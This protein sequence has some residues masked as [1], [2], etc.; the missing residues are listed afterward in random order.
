MERASLAAAYFCCCLRASLALRA[1]PR[2]YE[3]ARGRKAE[4]CSSSMGG[5]C[6]GT[7]QCLVQRHTICSKQ[8]NSL[9]QV[10][11]NI[12]LL[13]GEVCILPSK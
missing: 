7:L 10:C 5:W 3:A 2:T 13:Q 6:V 1:G 9:G 8:C 11:N 12:P 4:W